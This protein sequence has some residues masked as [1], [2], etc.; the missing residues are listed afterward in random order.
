MKSGRIFVLALFV[1]V[2]P[3]PG[4]GSETAPFVVEV[5]NH[6]E[7][8]PMG[9]PVVCD[10][11]IRNISGIAQA[12]VAMELDLRFESWPADVEENDLPG[13]YH[14]DSPSEL[15]P[16]F[17]DHGDDYAVSSD[18]FEVKRRW[19]RFPAVGRYSFR[20]FI[21]MG[22][23]GER[24]KKMFN[25]PEEH[26]IGEASSKLLTVV[27]REPKGIDAEAFQ[28]VCAL[29]PERLAAKI[30]PAEC[31]RMVWHPL[32]PTGAMELLLTKYLDSTYASYEIYRSFTRKWEGDADFYDRYSSPENLRRINA[33]ARCDAGGHAAPEAKKSE[34]TRGVDYLRCRDEWLQ[35][36]L[37][38]HPDTWFADEI[39][40][41]LAGGAYLLGEKDRCQSQL[42]GLIAKGRPY[43]AAK[44][45]DLLDGMVEKHMLPSSSPKAGHIEGEQ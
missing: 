11:R 39:R 16:V 24:V 13:G 15:P 29:A 30:P 4:F 12:V 7:E 8:A 17:V 32:K 33:Y 37:G 28:A 20:Y 6:V 25:A 38:N 27:V 44:A 40:L 31:F 35:I 22:P 34:E 14:F 36:A 43:V 42:E 9:L 45:Q 18:W 1:L 23:T 3:V 19:L 41:M 5:I 26:W 2:S 21:H 10:V